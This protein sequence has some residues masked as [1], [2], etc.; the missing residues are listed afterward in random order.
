MLT[1][2]PASMMALPLRFSVQVGLVLHWGL[3]RRSI[4]NN[5]RA[6]LISYDNCLSARKEEEEKRKWG[7]T[8]LHFDS[9]K[10][11]PD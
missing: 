5:G 9:T 1:S 7:D 2:T 6:V 4:A 8:S 11:S 3:L 10:G